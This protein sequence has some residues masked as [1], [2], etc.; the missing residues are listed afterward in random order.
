MRV[1]LKIEPNHLIDHLHTLANATAKVSADSRQI[2]SGDIFF[3]YPVGHGN[4]L[5]DGR[6]FIDAALENGA[7]AVVLDPAGIGSQYE[8]HPQCF[9]I[10]NLA[11]KAGELCAQW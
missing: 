4:A 6:Q 2:Q 10:E 3:A 9:A 8:N 1:A 5:R 7:A 11:E